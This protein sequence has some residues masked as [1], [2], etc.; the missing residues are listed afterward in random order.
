MMWR[1]DEKEET[2]WVWEYSSDHK[3][4][5]GAQ[6]TAQVISPGAFLTI[7]EFSLKNE[8]D[9]VIQR[10]DLWML[11][12]DIAEVKYIRLCQR[13]LG[14]ALWNEG[15]GNM[16]A[17]EEHIKEVNIMKGEKTFKTKDT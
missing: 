4:N 13:P 6:S 2:R 10:T 15:C 17:F 9:S 14:V 1:K 8:K 11:Q 16:T 5:V 12:S 7:V 3:P